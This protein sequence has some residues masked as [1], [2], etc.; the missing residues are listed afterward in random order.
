MGQ[1]NPIRV[2][3][4]GG[5]EVGRCGSG[6]RAAPGAVHQLMNADHEP[7]VLLQLADAGCPEAS[8]EAPPGEERIAIVGGGMS[9]AALT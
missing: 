8:V 5:R 9:A 3:C 6:D 2:V 7:L 1:S 4:S